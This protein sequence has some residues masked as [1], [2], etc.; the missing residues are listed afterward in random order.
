MNDSRL[1]LLWVTVMEGEIERPDQW[2]GH[3]WLDP[4]IKVWRNFNFFFMTCSWKTSLFPLSFLNLW[5][6]FNKEFLIIYTK[7]SSSCVKWTGDSR[8]IERRKGAPFTPHFRWILCNILRI[9]I[10]IL[11][12]PFYIITASF[13][14]PESILDSELISFTNTSSQTHSFPFIF[15][16]ETFSHLYSNSCTHSTS[17]AR[18]INLITYSSAPGSRMVNPASSVTAIPSDTW[19][20]KSNFYHRSFMFAL[21]PCLPSFFLH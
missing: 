4:E 20:C 14:Q 8:R 11:F 19:S 6:K 16:P 17:F 3:P 5:I 7:S 2:I 12:I 15:S 9:L 1:L 21:Q 18:H 10:I 13:S